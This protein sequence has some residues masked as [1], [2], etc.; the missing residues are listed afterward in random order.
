MP[1]LFDLISPDELIEFGRSD[2]LPKEELDKDREAVRPFCEAVALMVGPDFF[3]PYM[4]ALTAIERALR[5]K[6]SKKH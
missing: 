5:I 4:T 1:H 6:A 3:V 2:Q